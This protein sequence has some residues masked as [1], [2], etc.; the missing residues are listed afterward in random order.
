MMHNTVAPQFIADCHLGK[1][2][3]YLRLMGI[4]TLFFPHI[5]DDELITIAKDDNRIIL[6][7]DRLLSQRKNAPVFFLKPT[8]TKSQL[9]L[10]ID[11]Y[12]LKDDTAFFSRCIVCN[13][14]L[15]VIDKEKILESLPEKVKKHFDYFEYCLSCDRIYW[16]GDH[17]KHMME[18]L[19]DVLKES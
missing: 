15:Q 6:T 3:K 7:R 16:Q 1:L 5:E 2:A 17:Y 11:H 8:D 13:T 18:F 14:P 12:K 10:L 4:D 19:T 9:R